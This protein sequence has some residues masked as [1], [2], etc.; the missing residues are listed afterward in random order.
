M[1][2]CHAIVNVRWFLKFCIF[3]YMN[4]NDTIDFFLIEDEDNVTEV[5]KTNKNVAI[6]MKC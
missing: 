1:L 5:I 3:I 2:K 6:S 4:T